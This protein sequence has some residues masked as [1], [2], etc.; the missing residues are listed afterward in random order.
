[1]WKRYGDEADQRTWK[2]MREPQKRRERF[3]ADFAE[4]TKSAEKR[5]PIAN[6]EWARN[7]SSETKNE[8]GFHTSPRRG[9]G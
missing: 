2:R 6:R 8:E 3:D 7:D 1:L 4:A 9:S 5:N